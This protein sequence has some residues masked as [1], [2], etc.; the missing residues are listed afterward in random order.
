MLPIILWESPF[1]AS[2]VYTI[3]Y[4]NANGVPAGSQ[5]FGLDSQDKSTGM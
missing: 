1:S 5:I 4:S 2:L 3:V